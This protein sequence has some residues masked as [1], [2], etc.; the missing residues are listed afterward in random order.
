MKCKTLSI[1]YQIHTVYYTFLEVV[2]SVIQCD[3]NGA[4]LT[5]H[6]PYLWTSSRMVVSKL[7]GFAFSSQYWTNNIKKSEE[8]E[9]ESVVQSCKY[10][11]IH[12][13]LMFSLDDVFY[14]MYIYFLEV[15]NTNCITFSNYLVGNYLRKYSYHLLQ[16]TWFG[17]SR[18]MNKL[19]LCW[20]LE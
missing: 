14:I 18:H 1:F 11:Q 12:I 17:L 3:V 9:D 15:L 4:F 2:H 19:S 13:L 16:R 6:I 5:F 10:M 7:L 8:R 20:F